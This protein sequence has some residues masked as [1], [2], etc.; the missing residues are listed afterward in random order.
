MGVKYTFGA[1]FLFLFVFGC[2]I[3]TMFLLMRL[4]FID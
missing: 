3:L 4:F 2:V 1:K